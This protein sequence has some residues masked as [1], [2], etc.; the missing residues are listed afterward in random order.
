MKNPDGPTWLRSG[1][2]Y[3]SQIG[4]ES[5]D[6][7]TVF[8][9]GDEDVSSEKPGTPCVH[10]EPG[11]R[12]VRV[13]E[14][15]RQERGVIRA[16]GL[17]SLGRYVMRQGGEVVWVLS[18]RSVVRKHHALCPVVGDQWT[19]ATPFFWWQQRVRFGVWDAQAAGESGANET[20]VVHDDRG[21][22]RHARSV[23]CGC[24]HAS[25]VVALVTFGGPRT[26]GR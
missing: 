1:H 23:G 4:P 20:T 15:D 17:L 24:V 21:R 22:P 8:S 14:A 11:F 10:L 12:V 26:H 7:V 6:P 19:F 25:K 5:T 3:Y 13:L 9:A 18:V 2:R 16:E